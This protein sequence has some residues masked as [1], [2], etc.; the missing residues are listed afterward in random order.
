M[1]PMTTLL[2]IP[3]SSLAA[4]RCHPVGYRMIQT[5]SSPLALGCTRHGRSRKHLSGGTMHGRTSKEASLRRDR[6]S[7]TQDF[8]YTTKGS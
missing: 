4:M 1:A 2:I 5:C 8:M 6:T 3:V 7:Q